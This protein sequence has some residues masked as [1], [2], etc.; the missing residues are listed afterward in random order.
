MRTWATH[1]SVMC[2]NV[3]SAICTSILHG[4]RTNPCMLAYFASHMERFAPESASINA[5]A[6][7]AVPLKVIIGPSLPNLPALAGLGNGGGKGGGGGRESAEI[8]HQISTGHGMP[9]M[10]LR[11]PSAAGIVKR[12]V[13]IG[14]CLSRYM[15]LS[16]ARHGASVHV[17]TKMHAEVVVGALALHTK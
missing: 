2:F 1:C 12:T 15:P 7:L 3:P 16:K 10:H 8:S 5:S 9:R 14:Y 6:P 17:G 4:C 13:P 11:E